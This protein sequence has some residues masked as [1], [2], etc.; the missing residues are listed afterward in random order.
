MLS[1]YFKMNTIIHKIKPY[2]NQIQ[3]IYVGLYIKLY[4]SVIDSGM[5]RIVIITSPMQKVEH[6]ETSPQ[7]SG[8]GI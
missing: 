8:K 7:L 6:H 5:C 3:Y 1:K 4:V 2:V